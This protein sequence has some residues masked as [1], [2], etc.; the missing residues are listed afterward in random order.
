MPEKAVHQFQR[1]TGQV[2]AISPWKLCVAFEAMHVLPSDFEI[3][4][5][6]TALRDLHNCR[7]DF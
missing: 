4:H 5:G 2:L 1:L 6:L 3:E 7:I